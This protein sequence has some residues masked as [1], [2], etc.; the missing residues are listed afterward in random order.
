MGGL[1]EA[2]KLAVILMKTAGTFFIFILAVT[3]GLA[4]SEVQA[5]QIL[6]IGLTRFVAI[7]LDNAVRVEWDTETELGTAGYKLKRGQDGSFSYLQN[8]DG[9][10]TLFITS[11]GGPNLGSKYIFTDDTAVNGETYTYQLI[12]VTIDGSEIIQADQTVTV[13]VV[14]TNTPII[15]GGGGGDGNSVNDTPTPEPTATATPTQD[16]SSTPFPTPTGVPSIAATIT[17]RAAAPTITVLETTQPSSDLEIVPTTLPQ[18]IN[19]ITES[20]QTESSAIA[21]AQ[22]LDEPS[23]EELAGNSE[24][25]SD[26]STFAQEENIN[27]ADVSNGNNSRPI[28][29][30]QKQSTNKVPVLGNVPESQE[31][32][33][34]EGAFAGRI[35]LWVAFI[36]AL[37]IFVAAVLGAI[38]L[39][40]RRRN[41]E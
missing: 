3:I 15:L 13:G 6:N 9:N 22:A 33:P 19:A 25:N 37:I 10:G 2:I 36:A 16:A 20:E 12:E 17:P 7:P 35:Y 26:S 5:R 32:I 14:P 21:I 29:I 40:T 23:V 34:V 28:V 18:Q 27:P 31:S 1:G 39:Y 4:S 24:V 8:S 41:K 11:K 30:G 38:L